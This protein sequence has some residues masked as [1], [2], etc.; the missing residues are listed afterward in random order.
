MAEWSGKVVPSF[1]LVLDPDRKGASDGNAAQAVVGA[2]AEAVEKAADR[3][4]CVESIRD[5]E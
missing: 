3:V 1:K 4:V 5:S 2:I